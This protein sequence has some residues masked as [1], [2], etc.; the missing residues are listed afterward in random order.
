M[1]AV[2]QTLRICPLLSIRLGLRHG[3]QY[4]DNLL[5]GAMELRKKR[6]RACQSTTV[7]AMEKKII[8]FIIFHLT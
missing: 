8:C 6:N 7:A 2:G 5:R 1:A 3:E 4:A